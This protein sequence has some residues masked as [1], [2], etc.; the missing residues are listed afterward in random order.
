MFLL[1]IIMFGLL[2]NASLNL[3]YLVI[4][5]VIYFWSASRHQVVVPA[6]PETVVTT[7]IM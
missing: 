7:R 5:M 4:R 1:E 2:S 6:N 3:D